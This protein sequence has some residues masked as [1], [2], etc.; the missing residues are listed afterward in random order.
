MKFL[1]NAEL[2]RATEV[3]AM[4]LKRDADDEDG[5]VQ[6]D[7]YICG[8]K[9]QEEQMKVCRV[10]KMVRGIPEVELEDATEEAGEMEVRDPGLEIRT[11]SESTAMLECVVNPQDKPPDRMDVIGPGFR[12][13]KCSE[14]TEALECVV[15]PQDKSPD[16]MD[17]IDP[18]CGGR[19]YSE[20]RGMLECTVQPQDGDK[21][22]RIQKVGVTGSE[23]GSDHHSESKAMLEGVDLQSQD[24]GSRQLPEY[25]RKLYTEKKVTVWWKKVTVKK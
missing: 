10:K 15:N 8:E 1:R 11:C 12:G 6:A 17:V 2:G 19:K 24:D 20:S 22:K 23:E 18:G 3:D 21:A 7:L 25:L 5:G 4:L 9:P 14:S 13:R 16:G